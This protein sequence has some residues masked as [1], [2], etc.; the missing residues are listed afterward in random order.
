MNLIDMTNKERYAMMRK[1]HAFLSE[2][3]KGYTSLEDYARDKDEWF[4]V[5]GIAL[6]LMNDCISLCNYIEYNDY[7]DY[8][9]VPTADGRLAV[10]HVIWWQDTCCANDVFN[11][12]TEESVD[13]EDIHTTY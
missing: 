12:F 4:A 7:E 6:R 9:I 8:Y 10:S 3:V 13:E 1:R 11:I 2:T 5:R